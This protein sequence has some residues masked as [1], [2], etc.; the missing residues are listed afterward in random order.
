MTTTCERRREST[1]ESESR[2]AKTKKHVALIASEKGGVGK[3]VFARG[4][5][6]LLRSSGTTLAAYDAD[7]GVGALVRVLGSRDDTGR[8]QDEQKAT[9]GVG[10]YNI[11]AEG[12]R[13]A[14]LDCIA[15][16]ES[17]IVH[18][19]AGGSL[20]DLSRIVDAGEGIGGLLAAF[21]EH[22]YRV[23]VFHVLSSDIGSAQSVARWIDLAGD[24]VDHIAVINRK[25]SAHPYW[26]GFTAG[27]GINKGGKTRDKLIEMGGVEIDLP[28]IP[29]GT[30]AKL[31][32]ENIP[33]SAANGA[34]VL[35]I[36]E[37]AHISK[38]I[39]DFTGAFEPARKFLGL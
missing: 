20:Q 7:G 33:F 14:L 37:R 23:T 12:D 32:A 11:R 25:Y 10:Y 9:E 27:D 17:L 35:T 21:A 38:F 4:L 6:D 39:R 36:T 1:S 15:S 28:A 24:E 18:D 13:N 19:L 8:V 5:V 34:R 22:G 29:D 31:D 3:S 16:G 2:M 30:F 26:F